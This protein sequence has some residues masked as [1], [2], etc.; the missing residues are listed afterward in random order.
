MADHEW[1]N[2]I[3]RKILNLF[4]TSDEGAEGDAGGAGA[5]GAGAG[6]GDG[7]GT[8][9]LSS[10]AA[11]AGGVGFAAGAPGEPATGGDEP[12]GDGGAK[13][14]TGGARRA[15][16][17]GAV[18]KGGA[19]GAAKPSAGPVIAV[20]PDKKPNPI[21]F[22]GTG[23]LT[24]VWDALPSAE[25]LA[26]E[27]GAH[28]EAGRYMQYVLTVERVLNMMLHASGE[29]PSEHFRMLWRQL[30]VAANALALRCIEQ[31][32]HA[33]AL[34]LLKKMEAL[35]EN[36]EVVEK[37]H[38]VELSAFANDTYAYYYYKRG[39]CNAA[40]VYAQR[41]MKAH[42]HQRA[43]SHVA[44]CHLHTSA[45][46]SRLQRN[47]EAVRCLAQV[48]ALVDDGRLEVGGA[49]P[50]KLCLV[51]VAF[52]NLAVEQL[53]IGHSGE[54]A[55]AAQNA[56][57]LARLC[58]SYSNRWLSRFEGTHEIA[59]AKLQQDAAIRDEKT[60]KQTQNSKH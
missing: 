14:T 21:W 51:A 10:M 45:I 6:G 31:K 32:R 57:R 33:P 49:S 53:L 4:Y 28:E 44:K 52:H 46:L 19:G 11:T 18:A 9:T 30:V 59:L 60:K 40:L 13:S 54:A 36:D 58:L 47:P 38:Q 15:K 5:S 56:R 43:W 12:V 20:R 26:V 3:A 35:A 8:G 39:K 2:E 7:G 24:A 16:A 37:A 55:V 42:A 48:L 34:D 23:A 50:Q 41:A 1:E 17:G 29:P 25:M 27:L 22:N